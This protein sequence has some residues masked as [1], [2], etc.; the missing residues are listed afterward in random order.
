[1]LE[2][3][4]LIL[5]GTRMKPDDLLAAWRTRATDVTGQILDTGHFLAEEKPAEVTRILREFFAS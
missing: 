4:V 2:C 5:W 1:M 3:P